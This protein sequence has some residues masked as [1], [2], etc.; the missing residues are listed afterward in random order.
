[1][2]NKVK[3]L[4]IKQLNNELFSSYLYLDVSG[5]FYDEGLDGFGNWYKVQAQEELDHAMLFWQ[6]LQNNSVRAP[7]EL[8]EK[9]DLSINSHMDAIAGVLEH[10]RMVTSL[11]NNIY[12]AAAE[13]KDYRTM[14]FLDWFVAEQGEEEKNSEDLIKKYELFGS[15]AK[16]LYELNREMG[17]RVYAPPTLVL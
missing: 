13:A 8:I 17:T 16:A 12:T 7:L 1:M 3:E 15:D 10:E 9:P 2:D 5:Y 11:I 6:Y 4:L 14:H